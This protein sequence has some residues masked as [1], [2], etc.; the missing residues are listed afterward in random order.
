MVGYERQLCDRLD[1]MRIRT[2]LPSCTGREF[3][4]LHTALTISNS[5]PITSIGR[6]IQPSSCPV[7]L[8]LA[9]SR[10]LQAAMMLIILL[11][12][13]VVEPRCSFSFLPDGT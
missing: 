4:A 9:K 5:G 6:Q 2:E 3:V 12:C 8:P 11:F 10:Y 13:G 7:R 1:R